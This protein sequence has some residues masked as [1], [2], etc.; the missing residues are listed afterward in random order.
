MGL[1]MDML[2]AVVLAAKGSNPF[3]SSGQGAGKK[4][5][6]GGP[7]KKGFQPRSSPPPP[8]KDVTLTEP[9]GITLEVGNFMVV[10]VVAVCVRN[11]G[12]ASAVA[13]GQTGGFRW[14][15]WWLTHP[16]TLALAITAYV[17]TLC[18]AAGSVLC[19]AG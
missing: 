5:T 14:G 16:R 12:G 17:V 3:T 18:A 8:K 10:V 9:I 11:G 4:R 15:R 13:V 2:I 19:C 1:D 7:G 6:P